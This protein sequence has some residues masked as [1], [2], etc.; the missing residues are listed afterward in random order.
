MK[1]RILGDFVPSLSSLRFP[2]W[3]ETEQVLS[4]SSEFEEGVV[5]YLPLLGGRVDFMLLV[6]VIYCVD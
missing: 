6:M 1:K 2:A 3:I 4:S 5:R